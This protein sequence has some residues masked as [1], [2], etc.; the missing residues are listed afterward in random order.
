MDHVVEGYPAGHIDSVVEWYNKILQMKRF[1][2]IDDR[3]VHTQ[4]SA[5]KAVIV[6][7]ENRKV[8]MTLVEPVHLDG[9]KRK[10][11]IQVIF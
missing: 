10:G 2:S 9:S 7:E 3:L 11:Q 5:L 6:G 1:W 4:Y 8:Q